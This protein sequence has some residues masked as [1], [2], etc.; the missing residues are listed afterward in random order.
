MEARQ[1]MLNMMMA[2]RTLVSKMSGRKLR[3]G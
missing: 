2:R 1:R 3:S